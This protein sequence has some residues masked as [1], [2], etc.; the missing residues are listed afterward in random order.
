MIVRREF[1][2]RAR[3]WSWGLA[4][5]DIHVQSD[6]LRIRCFAP[7]GKAAFPT[8]KGDYVDM[9]RVPETHRAVPL[10][11]VNNEFAVQLED[12]RKAA[13]LTDGSIFA[14]MCD[15]A[16]GYFCGVHNRLALSLDSRETF[17]DQV[18][19]CAWRP[20][21]NIHVP[22]AEATFNDMGL[23]AAIAKEQCLIST[24]AT[25]VQSTRTYTRY[26]LCDDRDLPK[27]VLESDTN[28]I[29]ADGSV[30]F[31]VTAL[32]PDDGTLMDYPLDIY[33]DANEGY[34]PKRKLRCNG[35]EVCK[36]YAL[37]LS[38]GDTIRIKAGFRYLTNRARLDFRVIE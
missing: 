18:Q 8:I 9:S 23:F 10:L 3:W 27:I 26:D 37:G 22:F 13:N 28:T 16:Q 1:S 5:Y 33:L 7:E 11:Y 21:L 35:S 15:R 36:L 38:T 31:R 6:F 30:L 4:G 24:G 20:M 29:P 2:Y 12:F 14:I 32:D 25:F 19:S 34:L 17:S